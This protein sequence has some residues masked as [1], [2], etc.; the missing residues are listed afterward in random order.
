MA[1][2]VLKDKRALDLISA[3]SSKSSYEVLKIKLQVEEI[4]HEFNKFLKESGIDVI[5]SPV[6]VL[7][8]TPNGSFGHIHF[9][10]AYTFA[11]NLL[12]QPI[13][14]LPTTE[15]SAKLDIQKDA[16]PL[17]FTKSAIFS[18]NLLECAAQHF[19][20]SED[21]DGLPLGIQVIGASNCDEMVLQAM[22][23]IE[24]V[25]RKN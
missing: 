14:V 17:K 12:N 8:A 5:I 19:Y 9:C 13:G 11:W 3:I 25:L 18:S 24:R 21:C 7:P 2:F 23:I 4:T 10:A 16:W 6:H 22:S 20:P 1:R 15:F